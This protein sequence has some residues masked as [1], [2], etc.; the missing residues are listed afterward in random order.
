MIDFTG[1]S[2]GEKNTGSLFH[3]VGKAGYPWR[4]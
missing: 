2:L 3:L 1:V 4:K